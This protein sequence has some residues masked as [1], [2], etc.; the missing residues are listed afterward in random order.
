[1]GRDEKVGLCLCDVSYRLI[2]QHLDEWTA[3]VEKDDAIRKSLFLP[4]PSLDELLLLF[5]MQSP[6]DGKPM[7]RD[8]VD[9]LLA[10]SKCEQNR[11]KEIKTVHLASKTRF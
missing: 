1:M 3:L 5:D 6:T 10:A 9:E 2:L 8:D 11:L 4:T 7:D